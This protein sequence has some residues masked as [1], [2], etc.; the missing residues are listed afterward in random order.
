MARQRGTGCGR[1]GRA[2]GLRARRVRRADADWGWLALAFVL[3]QL[4][5]LAEGWALLGATVGELLYGRCVALELSNTFTV[6]VG[7][8]VAVFA[9]RVRIILGSSD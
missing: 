8:D 9:I 7:G 3:A 5:S 4:P 2:G 6:L 1:G